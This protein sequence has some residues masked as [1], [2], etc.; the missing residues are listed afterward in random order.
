V[1]VK[2]SFAYVFWQGNNRLSQGTDKLCV[3]SQAAGRLTNVLDPAAATFEARRARDAAV[4]VNVALSDG[5]LQE[6]R[7]LPSEIERMDWFGRR[8]RAE[9]CADPVHYC[10]MCGRRLLLWFWFDDTN[11]RSYLWH[12]RASYLG[13]AL[14]ALLGMAPIVRSGRTW[15]PLWLAAGLLTLIHVS[16]ITSAR[17]R[18]PL[19]MLLLAPAGIAVA[20]L[21]SAVH[22]S[23]PA[24][25]MQFPRRRPIY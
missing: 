17:F 24:G 11:P 5:D 9:L 22:A 2:N 18:I 4:A 13:L 14:L 8:I 15:A 20:Q 19:E 16:I 6:L 25:S 3:D 1:L 7:S 12:Y 21:A 10:R 23:A